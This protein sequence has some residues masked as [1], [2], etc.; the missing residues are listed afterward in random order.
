MTEAVRQALGGRPGPVLLSLPADLLDETMPGDAR[1]DNTRP[2]LPRASDGEIG[3]VIDLLA[4]AR[5]PVILAGAGILRARTST[6]LTRFAELLQVPVI[7]SWRRP[8]VISN[9]HPLYLGMAGLGAALSVHERLD[10]ADRVIEE[11]FDAIR[12]LISLPRQGHL[13][14]D[15]TERPLRFKLV[16]DYLVAYAPDEH[17]LWIIAVIHGRR[18]P[19]VMAAILRGRE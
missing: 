9:D 19:R 14:P 6:E 7:A 10:A 13:R 15:L 3:A 16:R 1:I 17:P 12:G 11:I 5:R 18:S 2:N 8:D 4:S